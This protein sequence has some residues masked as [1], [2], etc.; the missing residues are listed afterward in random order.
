MRN[1]HD[2]KMRIVLKLFRLNKYL[3]IRFVELLF[4][5]RILK[6]PPKNGRYPQFDHKA[7]LKNKKG[8]N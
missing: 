7:L 6:L 2:P 4:N 1:R 3:N 5:E 8:T